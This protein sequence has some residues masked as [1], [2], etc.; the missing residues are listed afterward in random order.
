M[1]SFYVVA[2]NIIG[3]STA[4]GI[5]RNVVAGLVPSAPLNFMRATTVQ[6]IDS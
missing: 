3:N 6:P 1:Y 5:L 2:S 4:S